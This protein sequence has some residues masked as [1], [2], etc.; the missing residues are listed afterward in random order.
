MEKVISYI[1]DKVIER[2]DELKN[3]LIVRIGQSNLDLSDES[4]LKFL[5]KKY[6]KLD[7]RLYIVDSFSLENLARITNLQAESDKE[8]KIQNILSRG[9]KVYII[10]EGRDYSS[11]LNDSKYGFRKQ[12]LDLEEKLYRYGAEFI[13]IS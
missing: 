4:L 11:V 12:I 7:G 5:T 9:G 2:L 10:K 3:P 8:K 13:S 6:Y 1:T